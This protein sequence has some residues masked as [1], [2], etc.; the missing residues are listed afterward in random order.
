MKKIRLNDDFRV[1]PFN[2]S[3][4]DK[5]FKGMVLPVYENCK[6]SGCYCVLKEDLLSKLSGNEAQGMRE[7]ISTTHT[8]C[9]VVTIRQI[10]AT[11][12]EE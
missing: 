10:D 11:L 4:Y 9:M 3:V 8:N 5:L 1:D 2:A 6:F 7:I 12:I